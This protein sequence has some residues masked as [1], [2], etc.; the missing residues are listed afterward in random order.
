MADVGEASGK[1]PKG[2]HE[3]SKDTYTYNGKEYSAKEF[4]E[5]LKDSKRNSH[6]SWWAFFNVVLVNNA[7]KL[8]CTFCPTLRTQASQFSGLRCV[9]VLLACQGL[10]VCNLSKHAANVFGKKRKGVQTEEVR[11]VGGVEGGGGGGT[12]KT[13]GQ[14]SAGALPPKSPS[15]FLVVSSAQRLPSLLTQVVC[16]LSKH[17]ANVF[18]KKREGVQTRNREQRPAVAQLVDTGGVQPFPARSQC[19]WKEK[20]RCTDGGSGVEGGG[21]GG[22]AKTLGQTS[23]GALP[24]KSPSQ[25][26]VVS[27]AQRL[28]SLLTQVVCNLSKHAANVFGKKRKGVQTEEVRLVGGVEGGGGGGTAKTLGQTS[29]GALPPKS[30]SQFLVVS[31]A[32]RLPSL[33]TQVVCNL[34]KHAANVFGK[35]R[36]GVQTEELLG[37]RL[38]QSCFI[39]LVHYKDL[40]QIDGMICLIGGVQNVR[41]RVAT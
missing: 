34:S 14:T 12:A 5:K 15:Q 36:K 39:G 19:V 18:G 40:E 13:L 4:Y 31:S 1:P 29:A 8:A 21:G 11:L 3:S 2:K 33:L 7:V 22:T 35:K 38:G 25:F 28:P 32:Q 9:T 41:C 23:A 10:V 37:L 24:P 20:G 6:A 16:N 27:S 17:A 30:P 26:L